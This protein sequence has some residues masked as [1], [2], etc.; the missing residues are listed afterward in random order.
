MF[1]NGC[2]ICHCCNGNVVQ[3]IQASVTMDTLYMVLC[4][5]ALALHVDY[6][7][8]KQGDCY[9]FYSLLLAQCHCAVICLLK[10]FST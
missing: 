2:V 4:V 10:D 5:C 7:V 8:R 6:C 9:V 1:Q 3:H